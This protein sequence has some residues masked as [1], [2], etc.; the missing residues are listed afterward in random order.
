MITNRQ[1]FLAHQAQTSDAPLMLEIENA[2]GIYLY[3]A[4]GKKYID[5]ISG[6]GVSSIGHRHP[7]VVEAIKEQVDKY[8]HLMVY[9][10]LIQAPQARLAKAICDT[11]PAHLDNVYFVNSGTEAIEGALKLAKRYT[12]KSE[13]ISFE[14]SYHGS[15][16]GALSINGSEFFKQAYRPLLPGIRHIRLNNFEDLRFI[17]AQTAAVVVESIQ[18]EAGI[19]T[20]LKKFIN[21][22]ADICKA[23]GALLVLDEIQSG[24]GRTGTF[25]AFEQFGITPDVVVTAKGMGGGMPIGAFI[26][27]K[28]VM[29]ALSH[30][31]YLGHI[32]TFGG[33]PVSC[34]A[35]LA[36]IS[37][38]RNG[39]LISDVH[40]K[41]KLFVELLDH[42]KIKEIRCAGLMLAAEFDSYEVLK[43]V[44]DACIEKGVLTDWFLYCNN[45]MRIAP[46]LIITE[47]EIRKSC[48]IILS[49]L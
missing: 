33:H 8:M 20:P 21:A 49:C 15:S 43:P 26:A 30:K 38:L 4:D 47:G 36:T 5:L 19:R 18:G 40:K 24:F 34:A 31:P 2:E 17:N 3:G 6:I 29:S 25:W 27:S 39:S 42:P 32:T 35:S 16:H 37:V 48:E 28:E 22:L 45:S 41:T 7:L 11:L 46:P 1:I 23:N 13:L 14:N 12:G 10:E 9:G 44:I